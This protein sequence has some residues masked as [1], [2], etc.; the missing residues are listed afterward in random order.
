[1]S[2]GRAI[3]DLNI[4]PLFLRNH[5]YSIPTF[6]TSPDHLY[7]PDPRSATLTPQ[8]SFLSSSSSS[9]AL[10]RLGHLSTSDSH[11]GKT[12]QVLSGGSRAPPAAAVACPLMCF[13]A[14]QTKTR[15]TIASMSITEPTARMTHL[16]RCKMEEV[17]VGIIGVRFVR[18]KPLTVSCNG[19]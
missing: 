7:R 13:L 1:M 12:V 9:R 19:P 5:F 3:K 6:P 18:P 8:C 10:H 14:E 15:T 16:L 17:G 4:Q 11:L 2:F